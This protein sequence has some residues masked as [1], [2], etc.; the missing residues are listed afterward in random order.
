MI[1][2]GVVQKEFRPLDPRAMRWWIPPG[3]SILAF[4]GTKTLFQTL[5]VI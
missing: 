2:V 3:Y 5:S 1:L 4:R